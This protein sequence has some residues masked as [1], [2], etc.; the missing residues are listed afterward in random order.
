M[1][2]MKFVG[3]AALAIVAT[4]I[5][6][7]TARAQ[8]QTRGVTRY[9]PRTRSYVTAFQTRGPLNTN[10]QL[11]ATIDPGLQAARSA[12]NPQNLV[13]KQVTDV[14][15]GAKRLKSQLAARGIPLLS[16]PKTFAFSPV[17]AV[18]YNPR[19]GAYAAAYDSNGQRA[20]D[21]LR[22]KGYTSFSVYPTGGFDILN[23]EVSALGRQSN[24]YFSGNAANTFRALGY[25]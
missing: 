16:E 19:T 13:G 12:I 23:R 20:E 1:R 10:P 14:I 6:G 9:D 22:R 21:I 5:L 4:A 8:F 7:S 2:M 18:A 15:D 25:R 17:A 24:Q 11:Q 3:L